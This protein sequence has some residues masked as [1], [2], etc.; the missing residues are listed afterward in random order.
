MSTLWKEEA[1]GN[2]GDAMQTKTDAELIAAYAASRD[3]SAFAELVSRHEQMVYRI[4][5]RMLGN[6]HEAEDASQ[7]VFVV[8]VRKAKSLRRKGDLSAWLHGVARNVALQALRDRAQRAKREKGAAMF[9]EESGAKQEK[10]EPD[11]QAVLEQI[12]KQLAALSYVQRQAVILRYLKG[13]SQRESARIAGCPQGTLGRRASDGLGK[14]RKRLER[15][16]AVFG[17]GALVAMLETEVKASVPQTLLP[18]IMAASKV[19]AAGAAAGAAGSNVMVLAEGAM[20]M[21]MWMKVKMTVAAAVATLV[22]VVGTAGALQQM[23]KQKSTA[24]T[25]G[26][27][28]G[29]AERAHPAGKASEGWSKPIDGIAIRLEPVRPTILPPAYPNEELLGFRLYVKNMADAESILTGYLA[30]GSEVTWG[31]TDSNGDVW[32]PVFLPPPMPRRLPEREVRLKPGEAKLF[33]TIGSVTG[34]RKADKS[35]ERWYKSLPLGLYTV[36]IKNIRIGGVSAPLNSLPVTLMAVDLKAVKGL[37]LSLRA[38][39]TTLT[40]EPRNKTQVA[41][42][43]FIFRHVGDKPIKLN[44]YDMVWSHLK[45]NVTGPDKESVRRVKRLVEREMPWPQERDFPTL[46]HGRF[47]PYEASFPGT[48]GMFEYYLLKPGKYRIKVT[49]DA[50]LPAWLEKSTRE[51][52]AGCWEGSVTSNEITLTVRAS[53]KK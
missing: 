3:E 53:E 18:S 14:L 1:F 20:K 51:L 32:G 41:K 5:L 11:R 29:P 28:G 26:Q 12:D 22:L 45:L 42:L 52:G 46:S 7:A 47:M 25:Q 15:R 8:L 30:S 50:A 43:R 2:L 10:A 6:T 33:G 40:A 49:Y 38:D 39:R 9:Q 35:D 16:V 23:E 24:A 48:F 34:F 4:C 37:Q 19:A 36:V 27:S 17:A 21:M 13:H 44:A 31:I